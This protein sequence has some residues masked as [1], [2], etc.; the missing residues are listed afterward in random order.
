[1]L[2]EYEPVVPLVVAVL[3]EVV[4]L[5]EVF[6]HTPRWVMALPP[7]ESTD[8]LPVAVV[9]VMLVTGYVLTVGVSAGKIST[10]AM[11]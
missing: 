5:G 10:A 11:S 3:F 2:T 7:S 1:M 8:P 6:Q 9:G 4:G